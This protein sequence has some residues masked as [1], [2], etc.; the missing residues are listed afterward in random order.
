MVAFCFWGIVFVL[1]CLTVIHVL[2]SRNELEVYALPVHL[3]YDESLYF[4][5]G[6]VVY[7]LPKGVELIGETNNIG[8][9]TKERNFDGNEDGYVY[10][11]LEENE[12]LYFRWKE[13]DE[14]VDGKEPYLL[15]N[16]KE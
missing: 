13:W 7:I 1:V 11:N 4:Y 5:D 14:S 15:L 3:Y 2:R 6:H 8:N 12:I 16:R 9:A 10:K